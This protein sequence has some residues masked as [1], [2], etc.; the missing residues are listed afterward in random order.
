MQSSMDSSQNRAVRYAAIG[1]SVLVLLIVLTWLALRETPKPELEPASSALVS[2][3]IRH[4]APSL[5]AE[6]VAQK[7]PAA[8][9]GDATTTNA[10]VLYRQAFALYDALSTDIKNI[11][12]RPSTNV[13]SLVAE[14]VCEKIRS[15]FDVMHQG[16]ALAN[17]DWEIDSPQA[18]SDKL[19]PLFESTHA[20][21][22][23]AVWSA[24]H[25]HPNGPVQIREDLLAVLRLGHRLPPY[26]ISQFVDMAIQRLVIDSV[27]SHANVLASDGSSQLI[28]AFHSFQDDKSLRTA[29]RQVA[30]LTTSAADK[31][32]AM[33][34]EEAE[35]LLERYIPTNTTMTVEQAVAVLR[36]AAGWQ[37]QYADAQNSPVAAY[38]NGWLICG[39]P[40]RQTSP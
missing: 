10:A 9:T 33:P 12:N 23:I 21:T 30:D 26:S 35:R 25:C 37:R 1:V 17:C 8:P 2:Q 16:A 34:P 20:I 22:W 3:P 31:L 29:L 27:A 38:H 6:D 7:V 15:I 19:K 36:E 13:D 5:P 32:A 4:A 14:M 24:D 11:V 18:N 28:E 39:V 40:G